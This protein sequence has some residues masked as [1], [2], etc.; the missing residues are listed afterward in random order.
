MT[1]EKVRVTVCGAAGTVTGS[2]YLVESGSSK[3]LVDCGMFQGLKELRLRNWKKPPFDPASISAVVLT[4]AHI[5][6]TGYLPVLVK[7]G[8]KGDVFCTAATKDLLGLILPD[9]AHLQEEEARF[10]NKWETSK[11]VPAE[12]LFTEVDARNAL[13]LV[14][15]IEFDNGLGFDNIEIGRYSE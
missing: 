5:D 10:A 1:N 3:L 7:Y 15:I 9:A 2:K 6:H 8:F 4:H 14:K 12:P 11:H 13:K